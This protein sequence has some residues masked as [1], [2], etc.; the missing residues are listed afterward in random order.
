[1]LSSLYTKIFF[2]L[3][4]SVDAAPLEKG[5]GHEVVLRVEANSTRPLLQRCP[6]RVCVDSLNDEAVSVLGSAIIEPPLSLLDVSTHSNPRLFLQALEEEW[7]IISK[8]PLKLWFLTELASGL[9]LSH[10][11]QLLTPRV[12][13]KLKPIAPQKLISTLPKFLTSQDVTYKFWIMRYLQQ[14]GDSDRA[15]L[16]RAWRSS[17]SIKKSKITPISSEDLMLRTL[18]LYNRRLNRSIS[19]MNYSAELRLPFT[20]PVERTQLGSYRYVGRGS[21]ATRCLLPAITISRE[22][23]TLLISDGVLEIS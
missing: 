21:L 1:M 20:L 19:D 18:A 6:W 16:K 13:N 3:S 17:L 22:Q 14:R 8:V 15:S 7:A 10:F 9:E 2:E 4:E 11:N 12:L 23:K 5:E